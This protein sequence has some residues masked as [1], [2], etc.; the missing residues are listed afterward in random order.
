MAQVW[1]VACAD[2]DFD[3]ATRTCAQEIWIPQP[4]I[5]PELTVEDAQ[6][7]GLAIAGLWALAF[8][9]RLIRKALTQ[10]Q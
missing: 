5:V 7:I 1:V 2:A 10:I 6:A 8:A 3:T 4:S 9:F